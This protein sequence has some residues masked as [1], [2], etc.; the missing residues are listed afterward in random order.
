ME[1]KQG[2][3]ERVLD[4]QRGG[5]HRHFRDCLSKD[6]FGPGG[7]ITRYSNDML[8]K[9]VLC[10]NDNAPTITRNCPRHN[11][12][13]ESFPPNTH[14]MRSAMSIDVSQDG[15]LSVRFGV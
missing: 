2:V 3:R 11:S 8:N 7:E 6:I 4:F 14:F 15:H 9:E 12:Y 5:R 10:G 1:S 13:N